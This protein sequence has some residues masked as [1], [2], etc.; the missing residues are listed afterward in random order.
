MTAVAVPPRPE[1]SWL[2][3]RNAAIA[4]ALLSAAVLAAV[5]AYVRHQD[6]AAAEKLANWTAVV[7]AEQTARSLQTV[8]LRLDAV[9]DAFL[10]L[11]RSGTLDEHS[12][13]AMLRAKLV[14]LPYVRAI[15]AIGADGRIAYDSDVGNIGVYLGDRGYFRAHV[16]GPGPDFH[17]GVPVRSRSIGTWLLG[18]SRALR[19]PQRELR[20]VLV[21]SVEPSFFHSVWGNIDL[22]PDGAIALFNRG[23]TLMMR[24]PPDDA[25]MGRDFSSLPLF[26]TQLPR[27]ASGVFPTTSPIDQRQRITGYQTLPGYPQLVVSVGLS[28][29]RVLAPVHRLEWL[30]AGLWL[31][32]FLLGA[33]L[34]ARLERQGKR[35]RQQS[36]LLAMAGQIAGVAPWI[37]NLEREEVLWSEQAAAM[38]ELPADRP[39]PFGEV[40]AMLTPA[41]AARGRDALQALKDEGKGFDLELELTTRSGRRMCLRSVG[42]IMRDPAGG[43]TWLLG[44]QQ[45]VTDRHQLME[46]VRSLNA[47]LE[48]KVAQRTRELQ[49]ARH[50]ADAANEA[51][52]AFL[53]NV[54]HE[55]RTPMNAIIGLTRMLRRQGAAPA[56]EGRLQ[57]LE[58]S[59]QH[60]LALV[61]D[62]LDLSKI[63]AG[64]FELH[65]ADFA[66]RR[67]V[68]EVVALVRPQAEAK[69][70]PLECDA[71][72]IP[73]RAVG[74]A[75][76]LRQL[77]FNYLGNAIK[78]TDHGFVRLRCCTLEA[79]EGKVRLRFEVRDTGI[80][81]PP[82]RIAR[83]F[84]PFEQGDTSS[85][86]RASG[87]GLGLPINRHIARLMGGEVGASS[88]PGQGST[89][90]CTVLLGQ[91]KDGLARE[92]DDGASEAG[93]VQRLR[94]DYRGLRVL[95]AEDNPVSAE[96][97]IDLLEDAG[98]AVDLARDGLEALAR[99]RE[100]VYDFVMMDMQ[101]PRMDGLSA[102]QAIRALPG[103]QAPPVIALTANVFAGDQRRCEEVGMNDFL[104]KPLQP[105]DLYRSLL[106]WLEPGATGARAPGAGTSP[107]TSSPGAQAEL[108][109]IA[110][111]PGMHRELVLAF[112]GTADRYLERFAG[113][114]ARHARSAHAARALVEAGDEAGA[115][116]LVHSLAGEAAV[117]G[118]QAVQ[119]CAIAVEDGLRQADGTGPDR[120]VVVVDLEELE[121][122]MAALVSGRS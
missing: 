60:L 101:M 40:L 35:L 75:T 39:T 81:I 68:D 87:T 98:M 70:L 41:S 2:R 26:T 103:W 33:L 36:E 34:V 3:P 14:G 88:V 18:A 56:Q 54:S 47:D 115:T 105:E 102:T 6:V 51:K 116:A 114:L 74:D 96:V 44:S 112:R 71:G 122:A 90:W 100:Q 48:A 86:R 65:V 16:D 46:Q 50:A 10:A 117:L 67:T 108:E 119:R 38:L 64:R 69:G 76:R 61:N 72:D 42:E 11:E 91:G 30:A 21:A 94:S 52:S 49:E 113:F 83:L 5:V 77:L 109:R 37:A 93:M 106:R 25:A 45:D 43:G 85:S 89:F 7:V 8:D 92:E 59:G 78:F 66:L 19:S 17:V 118:A 80:G 84:E 22:G 55:I 63:E 24:S 111:L 62:I 13:R 32:A 12:A 57:Q 82:E 107:A 31:A 79:G 9:A 4:L 27:A 29:E 53:A 1:A 104:T 120:E 97:A 20:Y 95:L 110:A 28:L 23:G 58:T 99:A 73:A 121:G 15:W